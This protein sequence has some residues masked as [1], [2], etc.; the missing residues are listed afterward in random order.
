[1]PWGLRRFHE[2]GQSHFVTFCC[3][4]RR[5]LFT[6]DASRRIFESAL[7]RVRRSYKLCIYGY[8][9]M[10]EH[11]HL[12]LSEPQRDTLAD[13]L[14]SLKQGVSRRLIGT[15][16]H[17]WQ[18]R[19]YDF[20]IRNYPQFVEKL[21]YIHRNPVKQ[22]LCERPEDWEWSSFRDYA[23]GADGRVE[24]ESEWTARRRD[25]AAGTLC[26]AVELPHSSQNHA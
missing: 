11:V 13:A 21:R 12:L 24:I 8:V 4:H 14:K 17:F 9:V 19:Y 16:E 26:A 10:P 15:A 25:R 20:N 6:T 3:Y 7:E 22:G 1:M 23:T 2:T 5:R 18:K